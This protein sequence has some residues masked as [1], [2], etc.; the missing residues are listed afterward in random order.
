MDEE[1][2][3]KRARI[4]YEEGS[5]IKI[6]EGMYLNKIKGIPSND[7]YKS[8]HIKDLI[9]NIHPQ[10]SIF[11]TFYYE[12]DFFNE[13]Y[14]DHRSGMDNITLIIGVDRNIIRKVREE[15]E[16][17]NDNI[18][19]RY[20][21]MEA[22]STHHT[23][24]SIFFGE[25]KKPHIVIGSANLNSDEWDNIT[26]ALYYVIGKEK[27]EGYRSEDDFFLADLI[28]YFE[29]GYKNQI[30]YEEI[31]QP[32][33]EEL[34][35]WSFLHIKDR[36]IFSIYGSKIPKFMKDFGMNKIKLLLEGNKEKLGLISYFVIQ[37]SSIGFI[38]TSEKKWLVD[39]FLKSLTNEGLNSL[40]K[41]KIIYPSLDDVR[42][43]INGY[44]S[45]YLFP[46]SVRNKEKQ[47]KYID[48]C[49]HRWS[50]E[51]LKRTRYLPH[52]KTYTAFDS[53]NK[54]IYQFIGSQNL[55]KAAWG[56][57]DGY[58]TFTM[59]NYEL[60]IFTFDEKSMIVPYDIPLVKYQS[61][62]KIWTMNE[63]HTEVDC[64]GCKYIIE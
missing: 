7:K 4:K 11:F 20:V 55:S 51:T 32:L 13:I 50:S 23:K 15:E 19:K 12:N 2:V 18:R 59:K 43:S 26:Q 10:K 38:G 62:Q 31:I 28:Q 17:I 42:N 34:K 27:S 8:I 60:G 58:G 47:G 21:P 46:Y 48:P 39:S 44:G 24:L 52:I 37:C 33:I 41:L 54:P 1:P 14:E 63:N 9:N 36:L 30:F 6:L 57:I 40:D 45:G 53:N 16:N 22:Y 56:E 64:H 25:D 29:T 49:L 3:L 35:V 61:D 5:D